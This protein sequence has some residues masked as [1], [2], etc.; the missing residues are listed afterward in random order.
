MC[1]LAQ[2]PSLCT[3]CKTCRD[4]YECVGRCPREKYIDEYGI[5]QLCHPN[6]VTGCTGPVSVRAA[7][8]TDFRRATSS[9][10]RA[11]AKRDFMT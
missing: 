6:C 8:S 2:G 5:C 7:T 4:G 9:T 10:D 11:P 3:R 1:M